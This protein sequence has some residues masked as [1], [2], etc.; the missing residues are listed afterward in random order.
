MDPTSNAGLMSELIT[1]L[2]TLIV[3]GGPVVAVLL[4][5]YLTALAKDRKKSSMGR[6]LAAL[7]SFFRYLTAVGQT[8]KDPID[9]IPGAV[10]MV[11]D[12]TRATVASSPL[13]RAAARP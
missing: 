13:S 11:L 7:K 9:P 2:K 6:K 1:G 12:A 3:L 10:V 4:G 8:D 5:P